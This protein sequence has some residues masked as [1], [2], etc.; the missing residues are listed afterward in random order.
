MKIW[1]KLIQLVGVLVGIAIIVAGVD[2]MNNVPSPASIDTE[3]A[4]SYS[5]GADFYTEMYGVTYDILSQLNNMASGLRGNFGRMLSAMYELASTLIIVLGTITTAAFGYL[6][7][8]DFT[9][10]EKK[11]KQAAQEQPTA[12]EATTVE[13]IAVEAAE[14]TPAETDATIEA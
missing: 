7:L 2:L 14:E 9:K 3:Y 6:F 8:T 12:A 10:G 1:K 5:F 13:E 4:I 11:A